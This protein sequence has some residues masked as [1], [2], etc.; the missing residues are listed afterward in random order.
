MREIKFRGQAAD[1]KEWVYGFLIEEPSYPYDYILNGVADANEEYISIE[2][3]RPV[4]KESV[5]QFT[6]RKDKNGV[7]IYEGDLVKCRGLG[8]VEIV[9]VSD[10]RSIPVQITSWPTAYGKGNG[11][12]EVIGDIY[13]NKELLA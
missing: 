2:T 1:T 11:E 5:G 12:C 3:W 6:G 9:K 10:I 13:E 4:L 7:E 8:T